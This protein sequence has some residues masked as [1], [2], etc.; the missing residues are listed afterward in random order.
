MSDLERKYWDPRMEL[1]S[2]AELRILQ[3][4]KMRQAIK[5]VYYHS[6]F[7]TRRFDEAGIRTED[8]RTH[9]DLNK[10]PLTNKYMLR[11]LTREAV[12]NKKR[13]FHSIATV[14][15]EDSVTV[16]TTSGTTGVPYTKPFTELEIMS[17][18]FLT[19]D[20]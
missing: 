10:I 18:G 5:Q 11:D 6:P 3:E 13:P 12:A 1:L 14:P 9:E 20:D 8:I 4:R 16:H 7:F 17:R 2:L 19:S 15:E